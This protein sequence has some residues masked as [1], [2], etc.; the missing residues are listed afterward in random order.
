M[1]NKNANKECYNRDCAFH[2]SPDV[3][4][5]HIHVMTN[6]GSYVKF[7]VP[8]PKGDGHADTWG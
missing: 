8:K 3:F 1:Q 2:P 4:K 6:N 7:I 5:P